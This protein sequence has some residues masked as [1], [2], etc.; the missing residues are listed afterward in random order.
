MIKVNWDWQEKIPSNLTS[1]YLVVWY[2]LILYFS[3]SLVSKENFIKKYSYIHICRAWDYFKINFR[4]LQYIIISVVLIIF[5]L[6]ISKDLQTSKITNIILKGFSY[7][8]SSSYLKFRFC[9]IPKALNENLKSYF[10]DR[11]NLFSDW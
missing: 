4:Y 9:I 1:I 7:E 6:M 5:I 8:V 3:Q 11:H 2:S 10:K